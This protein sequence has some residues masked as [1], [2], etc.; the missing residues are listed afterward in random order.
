MNWYAE[1][2]NKFTFIHNKTL[3]WQIQLEINPFFE[4]RHLYFELMSSIKCFFSQNDRLFSDR[5][6]MHCPLNITQNSIGYH[7]YQKYPTILQICSNFCTYIISCYLAYIANNLQVK[8]NISWIMYTKMVNP[9]FVHQIGENHWSA[10]EPQAFWKFSWIYRLMHI[11][12]RVKEKPGR[13]KYIE[14]NT[15]KAKCLVNCLPLTQTHQLTLTLVHAHEQPVECV[16]N[17]TNERK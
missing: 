2:G 15:M 11:K 13:N 6:R 8:L 9:A 14:P 7:P 16:Q 12:W 4:L 5:I 17:R 1:Q 10:T 3:N